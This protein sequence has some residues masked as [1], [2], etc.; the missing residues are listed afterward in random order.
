[1][2]NQN[3][4]LGSRRNFL[5][6][7]GLSAVSLAASEFARADQRAVSDKADKKRPNIILFL[8]DQQRLSA[9]SAYGQTVCKTPTL[10]RLAA[11]GIRFENAYTA[12]PLCSPARASLMT[13]KHI[14]AHGV[15]VNSH[16]FGCDND[17]LPDSPNLLSRR[18]QAAGYRCGYT[19]KWHLGDRPSRDTGSAIDP[20]YAMPSTRGFTGQDFPGHG[21]GGFGFP[22]Y[23]EYL[24]K[25]GCCHKVRPH[26]TDGLKIRRYGVL[27]GPVESTVPYFLAEHTI[28]LIDQ[29][30][31]QGQPFFIWHNNW[32]PHEP[33]YVPEQHY[34]MYQ[35]MEIPP[36]ENY[37]WR[38]Q[39][40]YGPD[41][42]IRHPNVDD[43]AWEAWAESIRHYYAFATLID[44]QMGRILVHLQKTGL[45][46]NTIIMF[47]SDH[48]ETLGS[49]GG[50]TNKG[51]CHYEEIQRI[52]MIIK[53]PRQTGKSNGSGKVF[54]ELVSLLDLHP[55]ILDYAHGDY[56]KNQIHGRSLVE[57][58]EGKTT[59]WRDTIFVEF[60]GLA[61]MAT[62][63]ITCRHG[64]I[65]YGYTCSNKDELYDLA[66]DPQEMTNLIDDPHYAEIAEL[67][68]RRI[69]TFMVRTGYPGI[70]NYLTSRLGYSGERQ[71]VYGPDPVDRHGFLVDMEL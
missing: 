19:G 10:D 37:R 22:E 67:M 7:V 48:G 14:H 64:H 4:L 50:L 45:A 42:L 58:V 26:A 38:P 15:G 20:Q 47:C 43:L 18:L 33:Y 39:N 65:K 52:G 53:D 28:S 60:F 34:N 3:E 46:D 25:L 6:T 40:P 62:N 61:N 5:K 59:R 35:N 8:T 1:M 49:H 71:Y 63:M 16:N 21:D 9:I 12:C 31:E 27:E 17:Q 70:H 24:K 11:E 54:T 41:Q 30:A 57:L 68:K 69:Y 13:G 36:W 55:T 23:Q 32:G 44:E 2:K 29:F 66:R 51:W 56:D